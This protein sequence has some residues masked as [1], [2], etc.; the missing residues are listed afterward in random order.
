MEDVGIP[1][2]GQ[3]VYF[4]AIWYNFWSFGIFFP[5]WYVVPRKIWQPCVAQQDSLTRR[6]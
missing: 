5:I 1:I 6:D 2:Y 4:M 3:M